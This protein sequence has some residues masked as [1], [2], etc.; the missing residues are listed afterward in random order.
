MKHKQILTIILLLIIFALV[1]SMFAC[2]GKPAAGTVDGNDNDGVGMTD[3]AAD[4]GYQSTGYYR[5]W[6]IDEFLEYSKEPL[7]VAEVEIIDTIP[8]DTYYKYEHELFSNPTLHVFYN[9]KVTAI[10]YTD[11]DFKKSENIIFCSPSAVETHNYNFGDKFL[12]ILTGV[13]DI[14]YDNPNFK[15]VYGAYSGRENMYDIKN[16]DNETYVIRK[17]H[18]IEN[19]FELDLPASQKENIVDEINRIDPSYFKSDAEEKFNKSST[20]DTR[21][22]AR[23]LLRSLYK[24]P[25]PANSEKYMTYYEDFTDAL[26]NY[27]IAYRTNEKISNDDEFNSMQTSEDVIETTEENEKEIITESAEINKTEVIVETTEAVE[28]EI[29]NETTEVNENEK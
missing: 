2:N 3:I 23:E 15:N 26:V 5:P 28:N 6:T 20:T 7:A 1:A 13:E 11:D 9:A 4:S 19:L 17:I 29:I 24:D 25:E 22:F 18:S 16:I 8:R 10:Y 21:E 27:I 14:Y 12:C